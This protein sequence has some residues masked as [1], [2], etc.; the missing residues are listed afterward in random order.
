M[1][2]VT[3]R[4]FFFTSDSKRPNFS[5]S[6]ADSSKTAFLGH[7]EIAS[8]KIKSYQLPFR[9]ATA[10]NPHEVRGWLL[11]QSGLGKIVLKADLWATLDTLE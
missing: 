7:L 11:A 6:A 8:E 10:Q 4:C 2:F 9:P 1:L 5:F 3:A